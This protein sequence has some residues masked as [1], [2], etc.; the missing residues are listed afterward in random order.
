MEPEFTNPEHTAW[1]DATLLGIQWTHDGRD[2]VLCFELGSG[3]R[4][5]LVATWANRVTIN[6]SP[7]GGSPMTWDATFQ[8]AEDKTWS[9]HFDFGN[10]GVITLRA[11][12][13]GT[14]AT[15]PKLDRRV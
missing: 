3:D 14:F 15:E 8:E 10:G 4:R 2:L 9:A 11:N 12:E 5:W 7:S 6:L 1:S 13:V